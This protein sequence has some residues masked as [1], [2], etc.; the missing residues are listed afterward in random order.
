MA[1]GARAGDVL[2]MIVGQAAALAA[3]GIATRRGRRV[4]ADPADARPAVRC[5]ATRSGDFHRR[6]NPARLDRA[7][8]QLFPGPTGH[9]RRSGRRAP[10]GIDALGG[11]PLGGS[12]LQYDRTRMVLA[13]A[14]IAF[15][16]LLTALYVAAEFAA[17]GARRSRLRRLAEDGN[18]LAARILAGRRGPARARPLH[19]RIAS[20]HHSFEPD[21][22]CLR[23]GV[24]RAAAGAVAP[25]PH[26]ARCR[27]G[28][29]DDGCRRAV[30]ADHARDDPRRAG[31]EVDR[32]AGP[33]TGSP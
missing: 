12:I 3:V 28:R 14:I 22:R 5:R 4:L 15:L 11:A 19:C 31:A 1:L 20:R 13:S 10:G 32:A 17:V 16:I 9:A 6:G 24:D 23:P 33:D 25:E 18:A 2:E 21:P 29:I 26:R 27:S 30:G 8:R 7:D